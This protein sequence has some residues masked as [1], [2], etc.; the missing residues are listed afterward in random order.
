MPVRNFTP[1]LIYLCLLLVLVG[2]GIAE[3]SHAI[4]SEQPS[5]A[6]TP[7]SIHSPQSL[8]NSIEDGSEPNRSAMAETIPLAA[9]DTLKALEERHGDPLPGYVGGR[10]FLNRERTLPR[11][12]YREYDVHPKV[13]GKNRGAERIVIDQSTGKAYYTADH[14][15]SFTP[16]N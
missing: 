12:R 7:A 2:A 3:T 11:G 14:Y 16:M 13:P 1:L 5:A 9:R 4:G 15:R 10:P 8:S 6:F